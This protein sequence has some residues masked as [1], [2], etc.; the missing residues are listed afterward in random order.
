MYYQKV[1][2]VGY[3]QL[4]AISECSDAP[5]PRRARDG[6]RGLSVAG[7][8]AKAFTLELISSC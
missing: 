1:A 3:P 4:S 2:G 6:R 5:W 7:D 8:I